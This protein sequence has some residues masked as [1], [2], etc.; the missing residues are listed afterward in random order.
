MALSRLQDV[1]SVTSAAFS[2]LRALLISRPVACAQHLDN[3]LAALL[4]ITSTAS[5]ASGNAGT[6]A[7]ARS[8]LALIVDRQQPS[9]LL[10]ALGSLLAGDC[11]WPSG[12][13]CS[14]AI[15][16]VALELLEKRMA[17]TPT[18]F[19]HLA[20][21]SNQSPPLNGATLGKA[22]KNVSD[23][24]SAMR[25]LI[26]DLL[27]C[28]GSWPPTPQGNGSTASATVRKATARSLQTLFQREATAF[29]ATVAA[30][31]PQ[32][33]DSLIAL[34]GQFYP[35]V[36]EKLTKQSSQTRAGHLQNSASATPTPPTQPPLWAGSLEGAKRQQPA[37][38]QTPAW[39][40]EGNREAENAPPQTAID[41]TSGTRPGQTKQ[42]AISVLLT[43]C[44]PQTQRATLRALALA[45]KTEGRQAWEK[46]F[47]RVLILVLDSLTQPEA[48]GV[49]DTA[50][51]CLQELVVHQPSFFNDFAEVVA[52]KLFEAYRSCSQADKQTITSIDR[53]LE[54]LI[55]VVEA[56]RGLEILL[57]VVRSEGPPLLQA[58]TR[59]LSSVLQRMTPQRVL[60]NLNIVLP[61]VVQAFGNPS[62][63]VRKA[64][65]FCLVD[66]YMILGE[67]VMPYL[68]KDLT[69][70]Q[71]KL[72]T[73]Y[74]GRQQRE[75]EEFGIEDEH[76]N[77]C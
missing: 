42:P 54:R 11:S 13:P 60:D 16:L 21:R 36:C 3:I 34:L 61:G 10:A 28:S 33:R 24:T 56:T 18:V 55:G 59:L 52:S 22:G 1:P 64:A 23:S 29:S 53:T 45:A 69:A 31:H 70:S 25:K 41:A 15:R 30:L 12:R 68:V 43:H 48:Q 17:E 74:I 58:A 26:E 6:Q 8:T 27:R 9:S 7:A 35:E 62:S 5:A 66:V 20:G 37:D 75:R 40:R 72:V 73:I 50:I 65:V 32:Q 47:G 63:E 14:E 38:Y 57:P 77:D 76:R 2:V 44:G 71:M 4:A 19:D 39:A 51:L 49:R 46:H 67:Q